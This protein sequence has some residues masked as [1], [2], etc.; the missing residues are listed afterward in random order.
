IV[1]LLL[2]II[3]INLKSLGNDFYTL[4]RNVVVCTVVVSFFFYAAGAPVIATRIFDLNCVT[5]IFLSAYL[6]DYRKSNN[7]IFIIFVILYFVMELLMNAGIFSS[8]SPF[9]LGF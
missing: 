8:G 4:I 3:L 1:S 7:V 2:A 6:F 5:A 9:Y